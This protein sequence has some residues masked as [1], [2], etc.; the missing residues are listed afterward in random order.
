MSNSR[1]FLLILVAGFFLAGPTFAQT[2][3]AH[4]QKGVELL[5]QQQFAAALPELEM[6]RRAQPSSAEIE[7]LLGITCTQLGQLPVA[8]AHYRK[9]V[10]LNPKLPGPHKNLGFNQYNEKQFSE[11]ER[12]LK[13]ALALDP[14]D[15]FTHYYLAILYLATLQDALAVQQLPAAEALL[16]NDAES[17]FLMVK[18][19]LNTGHT[20]EALRLTQS[21]AQGQ[22]TAS[23]DYELAVLLSAKHLYAEAVTLFEYVVAADPKSWAAHYDLAIA[24]ISAGQPDKAVLILESLAQQQPANAAIL[25]Y[26]G[27][28]HESANQL[29]QALDAYQ[30]AVQ[31]D[32]ENP[33]RYLDYTRLL[34]DLDRTDEATKVIEQGISGA[35]ST[36]DPY[37]LDLRL[38]VLRLKQARYDEA[39]TAINQAIA[40][41]PDL[42]VGYVALAQS[43]MQQGIDEKAIEP[44]LKGRAMLPQDATLEYYVGLIWLRLGKVNEAETALKNSIALRPDVV[45]SHYQLGKLYTQTDRLPLARSEFERVIAI[46][47]ANSNAH[48]QLSKLYAKL[49]E[50]QKAAEMADE[51]RAVDA[52]PTRGS[53]CKT[54]FANICLSGT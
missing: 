33:D 2:Q 27:A 31:A 10:V 1:V 28:A 9:A 12:E 23:E 53:P 36:Q 46:A 35:A 26:L 52:E 13:Q 50:T 3:N 37:A 4:L 11:A 48:Y 47:P 40:L 30:K 41:H 17:R 51:T 34:M 38:G 6:A 39:R 16:A 49:G 22:L 44:L 54:K 7:N 15:Q 25:S 14:S 29:P 42:V 18:A 43:F 21:I 24:E 19:C 8:D 20:Q 5:R 32:P 45:E